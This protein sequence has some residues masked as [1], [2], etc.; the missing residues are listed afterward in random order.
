MKRRPSSARRDPRRSRTQAEW[1]A[2]LRWNI[3]DAKE[4]LQNAVAMGRWDTVI[5]YAEQ[6]KK[7][8]L[9]LSRAGIRGPRR[10]E[11]ERRTRYLSATEWEQQ[12]AARRRGRSG[13]P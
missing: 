13:P 5:K 6:L 12:E 11:R 3:N 10:L 2:S 8:E 4:A 1:L 7:L 9:R